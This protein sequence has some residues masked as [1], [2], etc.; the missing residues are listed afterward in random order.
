[1]WVGCSGVSQGL[2]GFP[3]NRGDAIGT[4]ALPHLEAGVGS[5]ENQRVTEAAITC[6]S[7][8]A[9]ISWGWDGL[10]QPTEEL[11]KGKGELRY[12]DV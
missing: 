3:S 10:R 2:R 12:E 8:L 1:M 4:K 9:V 6:V 5:S 7:S 11:G